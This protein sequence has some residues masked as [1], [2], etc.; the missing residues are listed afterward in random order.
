M[1]DEPPERERDG[2]LHEAGPDGRIRGGT[3]RMVRASISNEANEYPILTGAAIATLGA[4]LAA[5]L[6]RGGRR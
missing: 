5:A 6:L 4:G 2:A 1:K 3:E